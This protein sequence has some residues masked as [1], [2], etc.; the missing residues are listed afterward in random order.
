VSEMERQS[1]REKQETRD[2]QQASGEVMVV[3]CVLVLARASG[4]VEEDHFPF[5]QRSPLH[6]QC[7]VRTS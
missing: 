4:E 3:S 2:L 7:L 6:F 1:T 5:D